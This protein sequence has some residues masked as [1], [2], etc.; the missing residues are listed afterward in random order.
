MK[1][2]KVKTYYKN[3]LDS[4]YIL[5]HQYSNLLEN[6]SVVLRTSKSEVSMIVSHTSNEGL[7]IAEIDTKSLDK[8]LKAN[9]LGKELNS[10]DFAPNYTIIKAKPN[11]E[12]IFV[13]NDNKE[14]FQ[15]TFIKDQENSWWEKIISLL[16]KST[17][18]EILL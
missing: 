16:A 7:N 4:G 5:V 13:S 8:M 17:E 14:S 3:H 1:E 15:L 6:E 10:I 18:Q 9:T 12:N 2:I 11:F